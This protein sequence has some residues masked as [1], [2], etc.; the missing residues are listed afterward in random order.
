MTTSSNKKILSV[1]ALAMVIIVSGCSQPAVNNQSGQSGRLKVAATIFPLFDLV[2]QVGG[3]RVEAILILPPGASPHTF[4]VTPSQ[5]KAAQGAKMLFTAGGEVDAWAANIANTV[6][7]VETV[8]L[9]QYLDLKPFGNNG[10]HISPDAPAAGSGTAPPDPHTWLDPAMASVMAAKIALRLGQA[11]PAGK[12]YFDGNARNFTD[13]LAAKDR[14]WQA[15]LGALSSRNIVVF[16]DAWGYFADHFGLTIAAA[17]EPFPGSSPS[18]A[19]LAGLQAKVRE[20]NIKTLFVEPQLSPDALD[21]FAKDLGV[22]V[23]VLDPLGGV[24]GRDNYFDL[25]G[26]NVDTVYKALNQ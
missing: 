12:D 8:E 22:N 18:P 4:E 19:Y 21:T 7:G 11:D 5:V 1:F 26:Y 3:D 17:F 2:R 10:N 20:L 23:Q 15:E 13:T 14:E 24:A 6:P 25:I 16:H 9:N